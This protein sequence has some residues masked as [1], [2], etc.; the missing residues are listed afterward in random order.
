MITNISVEFDE[1]TSRFQRPGAAIRNENRIL[2]KI[3]R[4]AD[5]S[6]P[7]NIE[8][9]IPLT[10]AEQADFKALCEKIEA[11]VKTEVTS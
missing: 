2:A 4:Q 11:R 3:E 6:G 8:M 5:P 9:Q 7:F 1:V 10:D